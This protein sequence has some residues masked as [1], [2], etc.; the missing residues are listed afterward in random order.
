MEERD[1]ATTMITTDVNAT[2][3]TTTPSPTFDKTYFE[4]AH[5]I[6]ININNLDT[7]TYIFLI[8]VVLVV[9][10]IIY[11]VYYAMDYLFRIRCRRPDE[12]EGLRGVRYDNQLARA[13]DYYT[14][15]RGSRLLNS[16]STPI[17]KSNGDITGYER[18]MRQFGNES[19]RPPFID[20]SPP[21][22]TVVD[23]SSLP[24]SSIRRPASVI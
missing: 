16:T 4:S 8:V 13:I 19:R 7:V 9:S 15:G 12:Y 23:L 17:S 24:S 1:V 3:T 22:R 18:Y 2:Y 20:N 6:L 10:L 11:L 14:S 21:H 5:N